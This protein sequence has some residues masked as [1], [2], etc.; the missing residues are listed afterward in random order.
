MAGVSLSGVTRRFGRAAPAVNDVSL[1]LRDGEFLALLGPSGCGKTT[2]LRLI[3][4]FERPDA[5]EIRIGGDIVAGG[6]VFL[7]PERR[8]IGMVFQSYALWPHMSVSRNVGYPLEVRGIRGAGFDAQVNKALA[9]VGLSGLGDRRPSALSGG[10]RQRVALARC[11]VMEPA[12]VL[13]D[14]PLANL[15]PHLRASLQAEFAAFHK[16]SGATMLYVTHDQTEALALADRV[17]VLDHGRVVQVATP[18]DLY[19]APATAMVA[20]FVGRGAVVPAEMLGAPSDG[21]ARVRVLGLERLLRVTGRPSGLVQACLRPEELVLSADGAAARVTGRRF[22][23]AAVALDLDCSG[24]RLHLLLPPG[25]VPDATE[26][27][28]DIRDGWVIPD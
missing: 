14:E 8:R 6:A 23:G 9:T 4:G 22:E 25:E 21:R 10:Q 16:A 3:A 18:Q 11:L 24:E 2:L 1:D 7:P 26:L 5:G 27:R 13:L 28:V 17:A 12:V 20:G 15:D 19:R